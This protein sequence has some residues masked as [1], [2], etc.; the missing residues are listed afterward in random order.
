M[1]PS[2]MRSDSGPTV[3]GGGPDLFVS[4]CWS[5]WPRM[6]G[7]DP[8]EVEKAKTAFKS[9]GWGYGLAALAP[10]VVGI[11]RLPRARPRPG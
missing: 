3:V 6:T 11:C 5:L 1:P 9:A 2:P 4:G 8:A 7:G 10:L